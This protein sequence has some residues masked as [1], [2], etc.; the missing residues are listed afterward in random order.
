LVPLE[1]IPGR[2]YAL[3][4]ARLFLKKVNFMLF[5]DDPG[6]R[7]VRKKRAKKLG[8]FRSTVRR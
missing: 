6:I 7:L 1:S 8:I 3:L 2:S 4:V 5:A